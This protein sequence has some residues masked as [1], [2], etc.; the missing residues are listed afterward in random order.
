MNSSQRQIG[1]NS[2]EYVTGLYRRI[3]RFGQ[4][5]NVNIYVITSNADGAVVQN[6]DVTPDEMGASRNTAT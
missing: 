5:R 4:K 6:K 2:H 3:W 1:R